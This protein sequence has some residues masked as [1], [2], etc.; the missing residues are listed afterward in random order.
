[1]SAKQEFEKKAEEIVDLASQWN[2]FE[3]KRDVSKVDKSKVL[4]GVLD[5]LYSDTKYSASTAGLKTNRI[6][7]ILGGYRN[8]EIDELCVRVTAYNKK[9]LAEQDGRSETE[10]H[11]DSMYG[12]GNW[13]DRDREDYEG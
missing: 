6:I 9:V 11:L 2:E 3:M 7:G 13:D 1:M 5:I 4:K 10:K 8:P 12:V